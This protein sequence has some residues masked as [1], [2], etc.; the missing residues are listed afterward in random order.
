MG[1]VTL[2][3]VSS[4]L[5]EKHFAAPDGG[6]TR[7]IGTGDILTRTALPCLSLPCCEKHSRFV[8]CHKPVSVLLAIFILSRNQFSL[9]ISHV[10]RAKSPIFVYVHSSA[11]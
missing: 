1:R 9:N 10:S 7:K 5:S 2:R 3:S 6:G 4:F 11:G 8:S